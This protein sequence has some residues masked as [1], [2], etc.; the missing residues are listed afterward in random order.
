MDREDR[1]AGI[2][3][4]VGER[5]GLG[6]TVDRR[7]Q[8][9]RT[10]RPHGRRRFE[11]R[12]LTIRRLVGAGAGPDVQDRTRLPQCG[13]DLPGDRRIGLAVARVVAADHPVIGVSGTSVGTAV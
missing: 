7:C 12:D 11:R 9:R 13:M 5:Q 4:L 1:H 3:R 8:G 2:E 10:L 6:H